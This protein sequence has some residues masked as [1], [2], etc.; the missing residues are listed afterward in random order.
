M[1]IAWK[2]PQRKWGIGQHNLQYISKFKATYEWRLTWKIQ[3]WKEWQ[4]RSEKISSCQPLCEIRPSGRLFIGSWSAYVSVF[5][6]NEDWAASA[7][8]AGPGSFCAVEG[9]CCT[10]ALFCFGVAGVISQQKILR[11]CV[12]LAS[13]LQGHPDMKHIAGVDM[14]SGSLGQGVSAAVGMALSAKLQEKG[15]PRLCDAGRW[16]A[17][18][19]VRSG[20]QRCLPAAHGLDNLTVIVD[21]NNLQ[22]DGEISEI[23]SPYPL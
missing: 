20:K 6:R 13:V 17:W 18:R 23:C 9:A 8:A 4:M 10:G 2:L 11:P 5:W 1:L 14:S 12:I 7:Q 21:N 15:F 16:W 22:I 3:R 19:R